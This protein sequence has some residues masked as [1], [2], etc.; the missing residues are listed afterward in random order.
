M[1]DL[2][3]YEQEYSGM[4]ERENGYYYIAAD[5]D[6]VIDK[7]QSRIDELEAENKDLSQLASMYLAKSDELEARV[8]VM[9]K[10]VMGHKKRRGVSDLK[11]DNLLTKYHDVS[12]KEIKLNTLIESIKDEF[13]LI[14]E[15]TIFGGEVIDED[16][17]YVEHFIMMERKRLHHLLK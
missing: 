2:R 10:E 16:K 15:V 11:A 3:R 7:L 17:H 9:Q 14:D 1:S 5:A 12:N 8:K 6:E 13:P 4:V